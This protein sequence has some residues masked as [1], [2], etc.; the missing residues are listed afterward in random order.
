M[1]IPT[2]ILKVGDF[3]DKAIKPYV[4]SNVNDAD[5]LGL[6]DELYEILVRDLVYP[7]GYTEADLSNPPSKKVIWALRYYVSYEVCK[8]NM[9]KNLVSTLDGQ[10]LAKDEWGE[11]MGEYQE[12]YETAKAGLDAESFVDEPKGPSSTLTHTILRK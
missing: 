12:L 1:A 8:D 11:K 10:T 5:Y 3:R 2:D 6:G 4:D 7:D 9:T